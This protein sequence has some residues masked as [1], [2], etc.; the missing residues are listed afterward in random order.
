[1][2]VLK[3]IV[4]DYV[5][6]DTTVR[7]L[8]DVSIAFRKNEFVSILGHSGCG[9]TT[10]LNIIGGLD[11]YT[12]G[13]MSVKGISTEKYND[14]DW[15]T[16][17]NHSI[18][19]VFQSYNL[20]PHQT[21]LSNVELALTLSGVSK[22]ERR[23]RAEEVLAK[24]GLADQIHKKPNQMSG[25]QMQRVAI[26]RALIND[27]EILLADEPTGAL[28]TDTSVQIMDI[29]KE[30]SKDK[31]IIMVT[32]NPELAEQYSDR[33][34]RLK[35]GKITGDTKPFSVEDEENEVKADA[36]SKDRSAESVKAAKKK[37]KKRPTM[38]FWTALTLSFNNLLTKKTRT[39]LTSFAGSIGIIGIALI[40]SLSNGINAYIEKIQ[41]ETLSS[42][43]IIL[44]KEEVNMSALITS[45]MGS[46]S[47]KQDRDKDKIY[48]NTV[49]YDL[50]TSMLTPETNTNNLE[51]FKEYLESGKSNISEYV[52][53]IRY[54]YDV[55]V[56]AYIKDD[57]NKYYK[58]DIAALF[59]NMA[60]DMGLS[61]GTASMMTSGFDTYKVWEELMPPANKESGEFFHPMIK[62]Q[63]E[64]V[65]GDWPTDKSHVLLVVSP[66]NEITDLTLYTL[67]LASADTMLDTMLDAMKGDKV[68]TSVETSY[69]FEEL[70]NVKYKLIPTS[71][72][73]VKEDEEWLDLRTKSDDTDLNGVIASGLE[74]QIVG[75]IRQNEEATAGSISGSLVYTSA[76]TEYIMDETAKS[77]IVISQKA[78]LDHDVFTGLPFKANP[79]DIISDG[80]KPEAFK[81]YISLSS[82]AKRAEIYRSILTTPTEEFVQA[83]TALYLNGMGVTEDKSKEELLNIVLTYAGDGN[84]ELAEK[85]FDSFEA[86]E[87]YNYIKQFA[88]DMVREQYAEE[89]QTAISAIEN[90]PTATE[91]DAEM[92][93]VLVDLIGDFEL[94]YVAQAF[95]SGLGS[96]G[97]EVD[98]NTMTSAETRDLLKNIFTTYGKSE[99]PNADYAGGLLKAI[100][101]DLKKQYIVDIYSKNTALSPEIISAEID[102]MILAGTFDETVFVPEIEKQ[103]NENYLINKAPAQS[104][105]AKNTKVSK[106]F[107]SALEKYTN[108]EL[109]YFYDEYVPSESPTTL[110]DNF[111]A[112]GLAEE[113]DPFTISIYA[114]NFEDKERVGDII[115][116]YN[117]EQ[118][119]EDDAISYTDY[120]GILMSS[121]TDIINA[122]SY[123]LIFFVSISLVVSSIMIGII[124]Y[125]SVLER[126]KEIGILRAMGASKKDVSRVFNAETLIVGF[127]A[128]LIGIVVTVILN[129]PISLIIKHLA[130][131]SGLSTLP[132]AGGIILVIISMVL[133]LVSGLIPSR[134][135]AKKDPVESLRSE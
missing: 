73:F 96:I 48:L 7:A 85:Y 14:G 119:N 11:R 58:A 12:S 61:M 40:L 9:K 1:M 124:T 18:G 50:M 128:G 131:I 132:V 81:S 10:M 27:P 62:E 46:H 71:A 70:L 90:A 79:E 88:E 56:N 100:R 2:L 24:V 36:E 51:K 92:A 8:D 123:V 86:K 82:V 57:A 134:I 75:I 116:Q 129:V 135:A 117:D 60:L 97:F 76:L 130:D 109:K 118:E 4:K 38:S 41:R 44:Q 63:Y 66:D 69:S 33:I 35:D 89:A 22:A 55:D 101:P 126:T 95:V 104:D 31:L 5:S 98:L 114:K 80:E 106:A 125:I 13:V 67:G 113:K 30:I 84:S 127:G 39:F 23:R 91:R 34:I 37:L 105:L 111:E 15:D 133:T 68:D 99:N 6:G 108:D 122:I 64:L 107:E 54:G 87:L 28:D 110:S 21:V 52:E 43:P 102:K 42:Y 53:I 19:F 65:A 83:R 29:L 78:D 49:S 72:Y 3:N 94:K 32:H 17:R 59:E 120:M 112:L 115:A 25:G 16:Y 77:D 121:V 93:L 74:L 47:S 26:A 20:I 45:I 103:A